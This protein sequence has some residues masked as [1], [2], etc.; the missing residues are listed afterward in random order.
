MLDVLRRN[1]GSWAIKIILGFIA[2]T[3][4]WWG[5]GTYSERGRDV[6]ATVGEAKIS[7][8][9]LAET[10]AGLEKTYREVYGNTFTPE[11]AKALNLRKMALDTVIQRTILL[12]EARK[13][14]L[15]ASDTEVQREVAAMPAFQ[16][17]GQFSEDRY[18]SLLA[19]N[20]I[21]TTEFEATKRQEITLNKMEGLIAAAARVPESEARDLFNLTTRKVRLLVV[22]ADPE[23]A[24]GVSP[25]ADAEISAK[26]EQSKESY[27]VPARV[28]LLLARF[29]PG[30]FA[31][32]ASI[33]EEEIRSFHEG[34]ADKFRTD[35]ER[36][37]SQIFLPY[38]GKDKE[39]V[40]KKAADLA[41]EAGKGKASF[42]KLA[43]QQSK[44]KLG[45]VWTRRKDTRP[46]L[47]D[48]VFSAPVDTVVGPIDVSGGFLLLRV[49][50]I[51]FPESLPLSQVRDRVVAL[52]KAEK[53][54]DLAVIKAYEAHTKAAS[55]RDLK[56][57]CAPYGIAPAEMGWT[58]D[59]RSE[60][61]PPAVVQE[62]LLLGVKEIGP[63]K[64]IGDTHFLFQVVA[65]ED[66]RLPPISE[67]REK[68]AAAVLREKKRAAALAG[69]QK[70][71]AGSSA[72]ADLER[73]AKRA[74][75]SVTTT[76]Y[77][78]PLSGPAPEGLPP[79]A[80]VR[81]SLLS[82]S[83]KAPVFAK[84]IEAPGRFLAV[85]FVDEQ[86]PG[87]KEWTARREAFIQGLAEQKKNRMIEA[88]I[89]DR[90]KAAKVEINPE[91]LK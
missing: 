23:K 56:A 32:D 25:P 91:A 4:I 69:L 40:R 59:P 76:P 50:R 53:G 64:T 57:A 13:L 39:G 82:L 63:V 61:V 87:E 67:V 79:S 45:E 27:R 33:T 73:N 55:S 48:P 62:A 26:Y 16:V 31:G 71:L 77:F 12:T 5:V 90:R 22:A 85:A 46:E 35:E 58:G 41:V 47:A 70:V 37:V 43:K 66:S 8:A 24:K 10:A 7:M 1:A 78:S 52:L 11:M 29:E 38:A 19:Y 15:D 74:G 42:D 30:H 51:K 44:G 9:E 80:D 75:L 86:L 72:A 84:V 89:A 6:A 88:F 60:Q 18:R 20:R 14:G 65:K 28:K 36:L 2:V 21:S 3:F 54:K 68:V 34:N 49:N 83:S 17:N 81:K